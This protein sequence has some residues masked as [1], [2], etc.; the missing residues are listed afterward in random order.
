MYYPAYPPAVLD[1]LIARLQLAAASAADVWCLFDNAAE[2]A[3]M[4]DVL[5]ARLGLAQR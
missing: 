2:D 3:A 4:T 5:Y 1:A